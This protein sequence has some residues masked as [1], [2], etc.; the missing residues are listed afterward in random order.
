MEGILRRKQGRMI[1]WF[2]E[3]DLDLD[4]VQQAEGGRVPGILRVA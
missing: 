2:Q 4:I 3:L 1:M